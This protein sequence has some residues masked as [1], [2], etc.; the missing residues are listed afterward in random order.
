MAAEDN[1]AQYDALYTPRKLVGVIG[2]LLQTPQFLL[3]AA[4]SDMIFSEYETI[5]VD[6][7]LG[8][9][10][11]AA[12]CAPEEQGRIVKEREFETKSFKPPYLKEKMKLSP[13]KAFKRKMGE[14]FGSG[15][16]S[17]MQRQ[18]L[19][20]MDS[21]K[22]LGDRV[23]V[24]KEAMAAEALVKGTVTVEGPGYARKVVDFGRDPSLTVVLAGAAA[25]SSLAT[26]N[27]LSDFEAFSNL[28]LQAG[29]G[30][31]S[32]YVLDPVAWSW[33]VKNETLM[34]VLHVGPNLTG[35]QLN[36]GPNAGLNK[37]AYKGMIGTVRIW[38]Y[39][40][41]YLDSAGIR[42]PFLP[43]GTLVGYGADLAGRQMHAAIEDEDADLA[44]VETHPSTWKS[45]DP[46]GRMTMLQSSFIVGPFRPNNSISV[47]VV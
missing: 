47:K 19:R 15:T 18:M 28:V 21:F 39:Q 4:F 25:W 35:A 41:F 22:L 6:V 46:A 14:S 13:R 37:V 29:G 43:A 36:V 12:F 31:I 8:G 7:E 2:L 30:V 26:A 32:D 24:R 16:L 5:D 44:P 11:I 45:N 1:D 17:P 23:R 33:C 10:T 9:N 34:K 27:P 38:V 40:D 20:S 42:V 3:Q